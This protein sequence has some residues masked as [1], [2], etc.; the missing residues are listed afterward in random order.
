MPQLDKHRQDG[1]YLYLVSGLKHFAYIL[2][3]P[4][5]LEIV[6]ICCMHGLKM[7]LVAACLPVVPAC[8]PSCLCLPNFLPA[9]AYPK[10]HFHSFS[11]YYTYPSPYVHEYV[12]DRIR[13]FSDSLYMDMYMY[14]VTI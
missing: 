11:A 4:S 14:K 6:Y 1:R 10:L 3:T 9:F 2:K 7:S 5:S 13:V 12:Y 8:L